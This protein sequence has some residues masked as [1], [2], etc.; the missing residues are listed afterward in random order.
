[1]SFEGIVAYLVFFATLAG[2]YAILTL[3]LNI[4]WGFTGL[5]NI[6]IAGFFALGAYTSAIL[7]SVP[8]P[9][10][11]GGFGL[12]LT[13]GFF[14][15]GLVSGIAALIIGIPTLRLRE[16][17]LAIASI[18]IAETIRFIFLNERWL[19]NG[20]RGIAGIPQPLRDTFGPYYDYAYLAL[21]FG[22]IAVFYVLIERAVRSPWGRALQAIREDEVVA[23][24]SGKDTFRLKLEA[25]IFGSIV[26][27]F[28]G[29]L[30]THFIAF[31]GPQAFEPMLGTFIIWVMLIVGGSGN[32]KGAII[33]TFVVWAIWSMTEFATD[34]LPSALAARSAPVRFILIGF[35]LIAVLL[36]RPSGIAGRTRAAYGGESH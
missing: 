2:I 28:A 12:P 18:G 34:L 21:V 32:N 4:Q 16:D 36:W 1:M 22:M 14:A 8:H 31:I 29:S 26:M 33:G 20:T 23:R 9:S 25:L 27:G 15:A 6:G 24:A 35:L 10:L 5:F 7:T 17:Y 11:L 19:A 30:Y 3:G 13:I